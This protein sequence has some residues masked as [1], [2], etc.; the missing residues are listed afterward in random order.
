MTVRIR[1]AEAG[2]AAALA[3]VAAVT[4]PLA[5]PPHTTDEAKAHFI[6]TVLSEERFAEYLA[7]ASRLLLIAEDDEHPHAGAIGYTMLNLGEPAD[8]DVKAAIRIRPTIE[9]SKCY[10][11]PGHHGAGVAS[12]LMAASVDAA[13]AAGSAGMWLGVNEENGRAQRFYGKHGF[14]R[15]GTKHFLVGDRLEDDWV[16]ERSL[17]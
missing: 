3:A 5:C 15:V 12:G 7:D 17:A 9:L 16:M 1:P 14:E 6:A 11:M 10:V 4:F 13:V 2:D 8:A